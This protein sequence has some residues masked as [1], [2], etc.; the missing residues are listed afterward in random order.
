[1]TYKPLLALLLVCNVAIA[2][3]CIIERERCKEDVAKIIKASDQALAAKQ[4]EI[5]ATNNA[6]KLQT[7]N[8]V[9]V[10]KQ[11]EKAQSRLNSPFRSP[12]VLVGAGILGLALGPITATVALTTGV[13][14]TITN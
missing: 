5:D 11:L 14:L 2:D 3:S 12:I 8:T 9:V 4:A 6:L 10:Q 13:I 7:K 1:M